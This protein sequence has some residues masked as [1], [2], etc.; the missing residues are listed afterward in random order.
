MPPPLKHMFE[1]LFAP[2]FSA[3]AQ[4]LRTQQAASYGVK[5]SVDL[6]QECFHRPAVAPQGLQ[7]ELMPCCSAVVD[8]HLVV[9]NPAWDIQS[10]FQLW[11]REAAFGRYFLG[12]TNL[13]LVLPFH[14]T[15]SSPFPHKNQKHMQ[16]SW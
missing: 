7:A 6:A 9:E 4:R 10:D 16:G 13:S 14:V 1:S 11:L 12:K 15:L 3:H 8:P 2:G 5:C